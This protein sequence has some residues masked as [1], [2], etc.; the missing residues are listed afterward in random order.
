[1]LFKIAPTEN[2]LRSIKPREGIQ[3][4]EELRR[5][6]ILPEAD[7]AQQ[8]RSVVLQIKILICTKNLFH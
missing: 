8:S 7:H 1:M 2:D 6:C 3:G 4:D 5:I